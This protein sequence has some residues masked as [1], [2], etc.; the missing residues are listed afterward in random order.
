[1]IQSKMN[2]DSHLEQ[3]DAPTSD[4][5]ATASPR[6]GNG[7]RVPRSGT[8]QSRKSKQQADTLAS[9]LLVGVVAVFVFFITRRL[10]TIV[11][12]LDD[13]SM[14]LQS[15]HSLWASAGSSDL[16][17]RLGPGTTEKLW[18][19]LPGLSV[20]LAIFGKIWGTGLEPARTF[21]AVAACLVL[22]AVFLIGRK[23]HSRAAGL[24]AVFALAFDANFFHTARFLTT[25]FPTLACT[26]AAFYLHLRSQSAANPHRE[27][28][29]G[30]GAGVLVILALLMQVGAVYVTILILIWSLVEHGR[31]IVHSRSMGALLMGSGIL[32]LPCSVYLWGHYSEL[33][34]EWHPETLYFRGFGVSNIFKNLA[35]EHLRYDQWESGVLK[36]ATED[37]WSVSLFQLLIGLS[38]LYLGVRVVVAF[39]RSHGWQ[40]FTEMLQSMT[41]EGQALA[42]DRSQFFHLGPDEPR[43]TG[44]LLRS[45]ARQGGWRRKLTVALHELEE[46]SRPVTTWLDALGAP[47]HPAWRASRAGL[48]LVSLASIIFFALFDAQKSA[49]HLPFITVWLALCC[50]VGIVDGIRWGV[51]QRKRSAKRVLMGLG[52]LLLVV[53]P[54]IGYATSASRVVWRFYRWSRTFEPAPYSDVTQV[55][56]TIVPQNLLVVSRPVHWLSFQDNPN[57]VWASKKVWKDQDITSLPGV[58][59]VD[60]EFIERENYNRLF[61][62]QVPNFTLLAE[63]SDTLYGNI[64]V[65]YTGLDGR[66]QNHTPA[67]YYFMGGYHKGYARKGYYSE[68]QRQAAKVIW[69][70]GPLELERLSRASTPPEAKPPSVHR[71]NERSSLRI[72]TDL[73]LYNTRVRIPIQT[74]LKPF[75]L[76]RLQTAVRVAEGGCL[77]GPRDQTG[78]WLSE[79]LAV[80]PGEQYV[81]VDL[82]FATNARGDGEIAVSNR[83]NQ[84]GKSLIYLSQVEIREIGKRP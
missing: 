7:K 17:S 22:T 75:T 46:E 23:L 15:A 80:G 24:I 6:S 28:G 39:T 59:V 31:G 73:S 48:L 54:T 71:D 83:R 2:G 18:L 56:R 16:V 35:S 62:K 74:Q 40:E 1:M 14:I 19:A 82:V 52:A 64:K 4:T 26:L 27:W 53:I 70:A 5:Q 66:F 50:G 51:E 55:L 72:V 34:S 29:W 61:A 3:L 69:L 13:E 65:Y 37:F 41:P 30:F 32:A 60:D 10:E 76:Y 78:L 36:I 25:D 38:L 81:P 67:H 44:S 9:I 11:A 8:D 68:E 45:M 63:L 58:L 33:S 49:F 12:P 20:C 57:Y 21:N 43:Y 42:Q 79:P 47:S 77:V 84:P